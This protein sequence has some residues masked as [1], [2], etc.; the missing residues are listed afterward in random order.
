M[1]SIPVQAGAAYPVP[2]CRAGPAP[3]WD[4]AGPVHSLEDRRGVL[5]GPRF[6]EFFAAPRCEQHREG[7]DHEDRE[8]HEPGV[9]GPFP[10]ARVM[11]E[12]RFRKKR[13]AAHVPPP[14]TRIRDRLRAG[15]TVPVPA[16]RA[17]A[18][19]TK[20]R[21]PP[22]G[23]SRIDHTPGSVVPELRSNVV[24]RTLKHDSRAWNA[25]HARGCVIEV[26]VNG[27]AGS[28]HPPRQEGSSP[29]DA[30]IERRRAEGVARARCTGIEGCQG[31]VTRGD[32]SYSS[33]HFR[34][35]IF[36]STVSSSRIVKGSRRMRTTL[37]SR[38]RMTTT[39]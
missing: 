6:L 22:R 13:K 36:T 3:E 10:A 1:Y 26:G 28:V 5:G 2:S 9:L 12:V 29:W 16:S 24:G 39:S 35:S 37:P 30:R 38:D 11:F 23:G 4:A 25:G 21:P 8:I 27:A 20:G 32:S 34:R 14:P 7:E 33:C 18:T 31:G 19:I 15:I 17:F